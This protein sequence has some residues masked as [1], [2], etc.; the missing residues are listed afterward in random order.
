[1]TNDMQKILDNML[2]SNH[3][4]ILGIGRSLEAVKLHIVAA[5]VGSEKTPEAAAKV[6]ANLNDLHEVVRTLDKLLTQIESI[7]GKNIA[8][9]A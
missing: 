4:H 6:R 7:S 2:I 8:S 5:A 3:N 9:G 1:M